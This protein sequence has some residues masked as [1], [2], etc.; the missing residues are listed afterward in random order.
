MPAIDLAK[1][2][3]KLNA[4]PIQEDKT[5][6]M[7]EAVKLFIEHLRIRHDQFDRV[8]AFEEL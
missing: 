6:K 4:G 2:E 1:G 3:K 5:Q 8:K 7:Q